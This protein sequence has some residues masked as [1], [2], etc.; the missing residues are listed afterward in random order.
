MTERVTYIATE[1]IREKKRN[2]PEPF[3]ILLPYTAYPND[4]EGV[5]TG[6]VDGHSTVIIDVVCMPFETG[7]D[8]NL[9]QQQITLF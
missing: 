7:D 1:K 2:Q 5:C 6:T 4:N 9:N 3:Q 8:S